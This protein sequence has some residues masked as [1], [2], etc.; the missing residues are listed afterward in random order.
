[1]RRTLAGGTEYR[2]FIQRQCTRPSYDAPPQYLEASSD[3][4]RQ[5]RHMRL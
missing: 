4:V 3:A 1:M 5:Y 2:E